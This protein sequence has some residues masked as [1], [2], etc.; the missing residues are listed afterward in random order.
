MQRELLNAHETKQ[1]KP[2]HC[3]CKR[4]NCAPVP[5]IG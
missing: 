4:K 3:W 5:L 1:L 2:G